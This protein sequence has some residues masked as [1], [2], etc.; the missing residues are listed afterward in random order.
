M[1]LDVIDQAILILPHLEEIVVL[2]DAFDGPFAVRAE[3]ILD[4][5]FCPESL[6]KCAVP[7]SVIIFINQ[8]FIVKFL[9]ISLND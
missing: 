8:L 2:A 6:V 5:L 9:K 3:A 1:L 4:I 7:A